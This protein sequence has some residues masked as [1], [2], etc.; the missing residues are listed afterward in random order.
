VEVLL[1]GRLERVA[2]AYVAGLQPAFEPAH[3][4]GRASVGEGIRRHVSPG[5][6]LEP[7]VA[8]SACRIESFLDVT[9][10][11]D[12]AGLVGMI[13]PDAGQTIRLQFHH[14]RK[15]VWPL[16]RLSG[17]EA[18]GPFSN[19][20]QV[21]DM[22]PHLVGDDVGLREIPRCAEPVLESL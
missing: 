12:V 2:L 22:M 13:G 4:L 1:A 5:L 19:S 18:N 10:L 16:P 8:N 21:L 7:V 14:D 9:L 11:E 20:Q 3:A 15:F 17:R 6:S